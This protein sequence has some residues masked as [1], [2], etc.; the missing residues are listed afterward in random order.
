M[1]TLADVIHHTQLLSVSPDEAGLLTHP[2]QGTSSRA[3]AAL[4]KQILGLPGGP[5]EEP[6]EGPIERLIERPI[7]GYSGL[8]GEKRGFGGTWLQDTRNKSKL[9]FRAAWRKFPGC[10][11]ENVTLMERGP[12]FQGEKAADASPV[13]QGG[14]QEQQLLEC[15]E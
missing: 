7:E 11:E 5:I 12:G 15:R 3:G 1:S 8:T 6:I 14:A 4:I 13:P 2:H 10:Q 9:Y